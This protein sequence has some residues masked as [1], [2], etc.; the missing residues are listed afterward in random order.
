MKNLACL[1]EILRFVTKIGAEVGGREV[2]RFRLVWSLNDKVWRVL[3]NYSEIFP[4]TWT[5]IGRSTLVCN[6]IDYDNMKQLLIV[7]FL[8][9]VTIHTI[10]I[11]LCTVYNILYK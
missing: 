8:H 11:I 9:C 6:C 7:K 4:K 3:L 5:K 2:L 10:A 1:R